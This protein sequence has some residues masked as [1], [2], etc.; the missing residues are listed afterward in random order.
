M[1]ATSQAPLFF[2]IE[3][4]EFPLCDFIMTLRCS[5]G[6]LDDRHK[7]IVDSM[8][9]APYVVYTSSVDSDLTERTTCS[10]T[11]PIFYHTIQLPAR[12]LRP[13]TLQCYLSRSTLESSLPFELA[14]V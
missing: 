13:S 6:E 14:A 3:P 10:Q 8:S 12:L 7:Q 9:S 2:P 4:V 11:S 1:Q 5:V